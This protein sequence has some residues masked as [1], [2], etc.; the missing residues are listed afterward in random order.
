MPYRLTILAL[1]VLAL[2]PFP[3]HAAS[4]VTAPAPAVR[5]TTRL[6][7]PFTRYTTR[8]RFERTITFY[9]EDVPESLQATPRPLVLVIE[10]SGSQSVWQRVGD[11]IGGNL[12]NLARRAG[13]KRVRVMVVEKPGVAF[14]DAPE[15]VGGATDASDTFKRE[16]TFERWSEANRAALAAVLAMSRPSPNAV[17]VLGHSEGAQVGPRVAVLEPRVTHLAPIGGAGA[18]Q[19]FELAEWFATPQPGDSAGASA[20]RRAEVY[21]Q[22][23][24]IRRDPDSITQEWLGHPYRRWS[25]FLARNSLDDLLATRAKLFL[26]HGSLDTNAPVI[27]FDWL[28]A[29]LAVR[30]REAHVERLE[31]A[32]HGF[33]VANEPPPAPGQPHPMERIIGRALDWML[34]DSAAR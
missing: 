15:H 24:R 1:V 13:K 16:H 2:S 6:G 17:L 29:E 11:R 3:L 4:R 33:A 34:A 26:A 28:R 25:S 22:W 32:D 23:E 19:L 14:L 21:A 12:Q 10:G 30:G 31:G 20:A 9:L 18:T 27:S 8:D 5:D 7:V